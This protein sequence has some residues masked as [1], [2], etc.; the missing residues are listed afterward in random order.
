M[1]NEKK[2]LMFILIRLHIKPLNRLK[3]FLIYMFLI[4]KKIADYTI[5]LLRKHI[6]IVM[7]INIYIYLQVILVTL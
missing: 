2:T 4:K 6:F 5:F 7:W 3:S 1:E